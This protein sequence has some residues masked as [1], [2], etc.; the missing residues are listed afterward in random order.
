[1]TVPVK[2]EKKKMDGMEGNESEWKGREWEWMEG[3]E[4]EWKGMRVNGMEGDE[5]EWK[6]ME[7]EV[8]QKHK[9]WIHRSWR[10]WIKKITIFY[11]EIQSDASAVEIWWLFTPV[12]FFVNVPADNFKS[13][14]SVGRDLFLELLWLEHR[15]C[16]QQSLT[17]G[18]SGDQDQKISISEKKAHGINEAKSN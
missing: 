10:F 1:M 6:G 7:Y 17:N 5:S 9:V 13:G 3:N 2:H 15:V 4:S 18:L 11:G 16:K 8:W 12:T 14:V